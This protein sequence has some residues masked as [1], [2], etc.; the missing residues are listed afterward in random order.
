MTEYVIKSQIKVKLTQSK[1]FTLNQ[2]QY[3]NAHYFTLNAAKENYTQTMLPLLSGIPE[4]AQVDLKYTLYLKGKKRRDTNN[5]LSVVDK[6]FADCLVKANVLVDDDYS[7]L[8]NTHFI[9]G[10]FTTEESYV[11]I[12]IIEV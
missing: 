9:F 11:L 1:Y 7:R 2:N 5:I 10:G 6:F 8:R 12:N 4:L 3:R